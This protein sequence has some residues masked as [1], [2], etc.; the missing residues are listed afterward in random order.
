MEREELF[1]YLLVEGR[2]GIDHLETLRKRQ[3]YADAVVP[4]ARG[5]AEKV[6][7]EAEAYREDRILEARGEAKRF[8]DLVAEYQKAPGVTRQRLYLETLEEIAEENRDRFL[9]AG[10]GEFHY[11][12]ALNARSDHVSALRDLVLTDTGHWLA[13][14]RDEARH[15]LDSPP[16]RRQRA[17]VMGAPR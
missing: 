14:A 1:P 10:G 7:Q 17:L 8:T 6:L 15:A 3:G 12:P 11:I 13:W 4:Q 9:E 2:R 16:Q 5:E